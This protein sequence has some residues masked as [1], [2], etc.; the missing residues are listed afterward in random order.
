MVAR[1]KTYNALSEHGLR[2][3]VCGEKHVERGLHIVSAEDVAAVGA[4]DYLII[5]VKMYSFDR[6]LVESLEPLIGPY[7]TIL[8]P[9][10]AL[11]YWWNHQIGGE[12]DGVRVAA[13]D[14]DGELWARMPPHQCL[15][16][17]YWL[18]AVQEAPGVVNVKHIQRGYPI[19]ELGGG[20]A[21]SQRA[22][23]L[24]AALRLGDVPAPVVDNIRSEI[25]TKAVN[26]MA[27]NAVA[28]LS[29][30]T[31]GQIADCDASVDAL[32]SIMAELEQLSEKF[33]LPLDQ[34]ADERIFQ[35]LAS[36]AHTMS[37]LHDLNQGNDLEA[38]PLFASFAAVAGLVGVS[39]P[40]TTVRFCRLFSSCSLHFPFRVS[41]A[42]F[43]W[44]N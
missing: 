36:R 15:G 22:N 32:R 29:G 28:V 10:T 17:T 35:T 41:L 2:I 13:L 30:A 39:L 8:P 19:G 6:Q 43:R 11:P 31:N 37:M 42:H 7:T 1:G 4:V 27:F 12:S 23:R 25:L 5:T 33:A 26:S 16:L 24:A 20:S 34:T 3:T 14:P 18:S 40:L 9:T 44:R 21:T 38:G